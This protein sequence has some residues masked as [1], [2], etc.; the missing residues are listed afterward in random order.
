MRRRDNGTPIRT[1]MKHA[2]LDIKGLA[3]ATRQ[4]DPEGRGL[5][6]SA[7]GYMVGTGKSA[8]D[9]HSDRAALLVAEALAVPVSR[10]FH[11]PVQPTA[12]ESTSSR[13]MQIEM[14]D[15]APLEPLVDVRGLNQVIGKSETW[16]W[17]QRRAYPMTHETP[18]PVHYVGRTP[19][20]RPSE[21]LAWNALVYAPAAA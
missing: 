10:L 13:R 2:G 9:E 7:I 12:T 21:V 3:A 6:K 8:R 16:V 5:A 20:Y 11:E 18:F 14:T 15:P 19:K 1:A 4:V 17:R